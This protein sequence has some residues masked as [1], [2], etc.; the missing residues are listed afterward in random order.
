MIPKQTQIAVVGATGV[1]GREVLG[2]LQEHGVPPERITAL[3]SDRSEA[4]EVE[5]GDETLEVEKA[6]AESFR[7]MGLVLLATPPDVSRQLAPAAQQAGA[8]V[9]DASPAFRQDPSV[10][11]VLPAVNLGVLKSGFR[12]RIVSVPSALTAG[13][14]TLLEPLRQKLGVRQALV[15]AMLGASAAGNRGVQELE[16]QTAGLLSGKEIEPAVFPHRLAFNLIPQVGAHSAENPWMGEEDALREEARRLW[17]GVADAL[18]VAATAVQV[19]LFYGHA[20][21]LAVKL[22]RPASVDE[23]RDALRSSAAVKVLDSPGEKIYPMP[24]LVT[25]DPTVHVGRIRPVPG[26]PDRL[27]LFATI[28]NAG[29]G[30]AL[31]LVEVGDAL[32]GRGA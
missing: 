24:M 17:A 16:G 22:A 7:G 6:S 18:E 2:A 31:N 27:L 5:F 3:A 8:W 25:A 28:D 1:V 4:A 30:A 19:P 13:L 14:V 32:L 20:L 11:L 23:V 29:R 15:T 9:V 26:E 12:G 10:P 21:S